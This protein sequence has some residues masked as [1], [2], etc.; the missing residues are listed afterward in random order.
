MASALSKTY[1]PKSRTMASTCSWE[2]RSNAAWAARA[3]TTSCW[4]RLGFVELDF[5]RTPPTAASAVGLTMVRFLRISR[6][7]TMRKPR[8]ARGTP[9]TGSALLGFVPD[10]DERQEAGRDD[11]RSRHEVRRE[12]ARRGPQGVADPGE[13]ED[14]AVALHRLAGD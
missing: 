8:A 14:D 2:N 5:W 1:F 13:R 3:R 11:Q 12:R 4:T 9:S 7:A 6:C 10:H